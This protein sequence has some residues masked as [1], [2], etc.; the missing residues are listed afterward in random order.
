[1][2]KID[3]GKGKEHRH[4]GKFTEGLLDV[5][6]I[7]GGLALR[8][9]QTVVDAGCGNGYM[10]KIFSRQVTPSGKVYALDPDRHF[11]GVLEAETRGTNIVTIV[12]DITRPTPIEPSSVD[13]IYI[14]TV[15]HCFSK[16]QMQGFIQEV[17][18][19]IKPDGLLA[20]VEI[21]KTETP[22]GPPLNRR[23]SSEELR[24]IVPMTPVETIPVAEYFFMHTFAHATP[25]KVAP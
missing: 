23:F 7:L 18:R 15:I 5:E 4:R 12:G 13:L 10:S 21:E 1:M 8:P 24:T 11:I 25:P 14:S 20:I 9:G 19:L 2:E 3:K 16:L 22:F 6:R 17:R